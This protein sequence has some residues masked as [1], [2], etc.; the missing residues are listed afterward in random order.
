MVTQQVTAAVEQA[1]PFLIWGAI[2]RAHPIAARQAKA[3]LYCHAAQTRGF[4]ATE[5]HCAARLAKALRATKADVRTALGGPRKTAIGAGEILRQIRPG[6]AP[7]NSIQAVLGTWR[8]SIGRTFVV[9][10]FVPVGA[11]LPDVPRDVTESEIAFGEATDLA[12]TGNDIEADVFFRGI[13]V[14]PRIHG[15]FSGTAASALP[16]SFGR[17]SLARPPAVGRCIPPN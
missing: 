10:P 8:V 7:E 16:F 13:A 15:S 14:A 3:C 17:Q 6:T 2:S 5:G 11:P 4:V 1:P 9:V 12:G